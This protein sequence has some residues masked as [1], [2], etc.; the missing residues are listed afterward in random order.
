MIR[1]ID[2]GMAAAATALVPGEVSPQLRTRYRTLRVMCHTS[3]LAATYAYVA[4]KSNG[5]DSTAQAYRR[6]RDGIGDQLSAMDVVP[7]SAAHDPRELLTRLGGLDAVT[8]LAA[9]AQVTTLLGWMAR[10]ADAVVLDA[11][12]ASESVDGS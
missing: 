5:G 10:I 4:A 7:Q 8:Y 9:S 11:D 2:Q 12:P 1:R 3:G 6:V